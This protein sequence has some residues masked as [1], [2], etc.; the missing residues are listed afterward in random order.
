MWDGRCF[1]SHLQR[2]RSTTLLKSFFNTIKMFLT[3]PQILPFLLPPYWDHLSQCPDHPPCPALQ[4][5]NRV[6]VT[7]LFLLPPVGYSISRHPLSSPFLFPSFLPLSSSFL[8]FIRELEGNP[9]LLEWM[10]Q[11]CWEKRC[12]SKGK[13]SSM[14]WHVLVYKEEQSS[15]G[16][17][18]ICEVLLCLP[19]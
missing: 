3:S 2:L 19:R 1:H 8:C 7:F 14:F 11:I 18:R 9:Q 17:F 15:G 10:I 13:G 4:M 5:T 6:Q 12:K 16:L